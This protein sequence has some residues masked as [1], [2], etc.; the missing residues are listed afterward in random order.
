MKIY[1][2]NKDILKKYVCKNPFNYIDIQ[3]NGDFVCCPSWC[4][5]N[6]REGDKMNW[7]SENAI[8][9][10]KS[11]LDGTYRHCDHVVCPSLSELIN[12]PGIVPGNFVP[13][14]KF[15]KYYNIE[16]LDDV[17]DIDTSPEEILFGFDRSCNLKC[18]SCRLNLV[19][20]DKIESP[21][22]LK[23][24]EILDYIET[25]FS[26][27][28]KKLLITGSGDPFYSK[29]YRDYLQNFDET[30][31]PKLEEIQIITNGKMLNKK[32]WDSLKAKKF[33]K[34]IEISID[35][36][37]KD[38]YENVTRLNGNWD[39]LI[40][41][42][43]FISTIKTLKY[44]IV[45]MVVSELNY[46]EMEMFYLKMVEIF[47]ESQF[48]LVINFRQHVYWGTGKYTEDDVRKIQVFNPEHEKHELFI[49]EVKKIHN[50]DYVSH[51]FNH[52][53]ETFDQR[54]LI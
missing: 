19:P 24:L 33:I 1:M 30:K 17:K 41:N 18:P 35:A 39:V 54:R 37:S 40:D 22:H 32:M 53:I 5:T 11:V 51:N 9:I 27:S 52:L 46:Q 31:Y 2:E 12:K 8:D 50:K 49:N 45:S 28:A 20:N 38:T 7:N 25:N 4:G 14:E 21:E 26:H 43:K 3:G 42:L 23:K 34:A 6:I 29:I 10:R 48:D 47:G 15:K 36:G 44:M 13:I 16:S